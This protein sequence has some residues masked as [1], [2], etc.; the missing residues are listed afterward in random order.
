VGNAGPGGRRGTPAELVA[1]LPRVLWSDVVKSAATDC[2]D[3]AAASSS[4]APSGVEAAAKGAGTEE[5]EEVCPVCLCAY[6]LDDTLL[7]LP[8]DHLFHE[9]CVSRWL[10]QD[11]SCPHCRHQLLPPAQPPR[12]S[13]RWT[14]DPEM[15]TEMVARPSGRAPP[16]TAPPTTAQLTA[17]ATAQRASSPPASPGSPRNGPSAPSAAE[18]PRSPMLEAG[19][20]LTA[21]AS[22]AEITEA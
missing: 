15:G 16:R 2:A 6:E 17:A 14:D 12:S 20:P 13:A 9:A 18:Q 3:D 7:R 21:A 5:E 4:Q 1:A 22:S 19:A 10:Q 11:S 8:C